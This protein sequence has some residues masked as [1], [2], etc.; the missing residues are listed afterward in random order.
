MKRKSLIKRKT[1]ETDVIVRFSLDGRGRSSVDTGIPFLDHM[2]VLFTRHG[3]FDLSIRARGDLEVDSHHTVEDCGL[4]LGEAISKALGD[5]I[6]IKRFGY[7]CTPMDESLVRICLDLSG[8][9]NFFFRFSSKSSRVN[10]DPHIRLT[11]IFLKALSMKA[12][13]TLHV[14]ILFGEDTHHMAEAVF[15]GFAISLDHATLIDKRAQDIPSTK[16]KI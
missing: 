9:P 8:R 16:G 2:L 11:K 6:G 12:N 15:K 5:R 3:L 1:K 14:D 4:S 13:L 7:T 10:K